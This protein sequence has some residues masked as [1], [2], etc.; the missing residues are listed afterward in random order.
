[1]RSLADTS[2]IDIQIAQSFSTIQVDS[3]PS[4]PHVSVIDHINSLYLSYSDIHDK[5]LAQLVFDLFNAIAPYLRHLIID[6]PLRNQDAEEER[7]HNGSILRHSFSKLTALETFCS[8]RDE[9]FLP[10][11]D[12]DFASVS[13][14]SVWPSWHKLQTLALYNQDISVTSFWQKLGNLKHLETL[15]LTRCDG[16][17]DVDMKQKWK[18]YC[19]V[20]D[21]RLDIVL[22]DVESHYRE[23]NLVGEEGKKDN[24]VVTELK[25]PTSYYGDEDEIELCQEW[26]KRRV[27]KGVKPGDWDS[28]EW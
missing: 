25:V 24:V 28:V 20:K 27:L 2:Q 8:V 5:H 4:R 11:D 12:P 10:S 17:L 15:V 18:E 19:G 26:V 3:K 6:M 22:V 7:E 16:L 21:R 13:Q 1:M 23:M 9:C 14:R